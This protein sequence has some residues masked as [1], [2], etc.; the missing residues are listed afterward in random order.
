MTPEQQA[1]IAEIEA[2][3]REFYDLLRS[4]GSAAE[5]IRA[6][7]KVEEAVLWAKAGVGALGG[8]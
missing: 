3:A 6:K 1:T 7:I 4:I 2:V 8:E 5:L